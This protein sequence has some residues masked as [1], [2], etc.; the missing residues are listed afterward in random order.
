[1]NILFVSSTGQVKNFS[2]DQSVL[3]RCINH[4][5]NLEKKGFLAKFT[6]QSIFEVSELGNFDVYIF[7]RPI[8]SEKFSNIISNLKS[9]SKILIADYDDIV[10]GN[11]NF[12]HSFLGKKFNVNS[13]SE[14]YNKALEKY[15]K[16]ELGV[17]LFDNYT[18]S[19]STLELELKKHSPNSNIRIV[20]NG[21]SLEVL[22]YIENNVI[23]TSKTQNIETYPNMIGYFAGSISHIIDWSII[24][25]IVLEMLQKHE[26]AYFM[27]VS[28]F[29]PNNKSLLCHK[30]FVK[31][32]R[33][34]Y[35]KMFKY[36]FNCHTLVAP[37]DKN[38]GNDSKSAIKF[39]DSA[40]T[41]NRLICSH[42]SDYDNVGQNSKI[43]FANNKEEWFNY[44]DFCYSNKPSKKELEDNKQSV[45]KNCLSNIY[46]DILI[47]YIKEIDSKK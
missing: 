15:K 38:I 20:R 10:F 8:F 25:D 43:C 3:F 9:K 23:K 41:N 22:N 44:L 31:V 35:F 34:E 30:R 36:A 14:S 37:L 21:I 45:I 29:N 42:I 33:C 12:C 24:E 17:S 32:K 47:D 1:M 39:Y 4:I 27:L 40:I 6:S 26:D 2:T 7:H 16:Y 28:Q 46:T 11:N 5:E 19:T 13:D 18:V